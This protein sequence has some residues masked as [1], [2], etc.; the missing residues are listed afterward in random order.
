MKNTP[1]M[2][3][4]AE[5]PATGS[6]S[7][8]TLVGA[9]HHIGAVVLPIVVV[10]VAA[11]LLWPAVFAV[12]G[13]APLLRTV[14]LVMLVPGVIG[15]L[16]SAALILLRVPKGELITGGPFAVVKHPLYTAVAL[17][18]LPWVGFLLNTWLGAVLGIAL[19]AASRRYAPEEETA[20]ARVFGAEW[21]AYTR[22]VLVPWL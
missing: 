15:W 14:S 8:K 18:V 10:G 4:G 5:A 7:V 13:P 9:G 19:Y 12:G 6:W 20:L 2:T 1:A 21:D 16:W 17:L 3:L 22:R 11:N